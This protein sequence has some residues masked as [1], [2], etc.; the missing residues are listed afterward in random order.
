MLIL[1]LS[2][3]ER[4]L[5]IIFLIFDHKTRLHPYIRSYTTGRAEWEKNPNYCDKVKKKFP[6]ENGRHLLDFI[7]TAVL[8]FLIG[9]RDRHNYQTFQ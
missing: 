6:L 9:N 2:T 4:N 3:D 8:D 7:D 5:Y 1:F